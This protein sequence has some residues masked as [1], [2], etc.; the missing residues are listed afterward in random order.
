MQSVRGCWIA[1]KA[2]SLLLTLGRLRRSGFLQS[3]GADRRHGWRNSCRLGTQAQL[4]KRFR[5]ELSRGIQPVRFLKFSRCFNRGSVP[6]SIRFS[7]E[8]TVFRKGLLNLGNT[9]GGGSFLPALPPAGFFRRLRPVRRT[10]RLG[11]HGFLR[12]RG[13]RLRGSRRNTQPCR[14]E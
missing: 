2:I 12:C 6:F 5:V 8:R 13:R 14:Y 10:T 1:R 9:I 3:G 4:L 7:G 11:A